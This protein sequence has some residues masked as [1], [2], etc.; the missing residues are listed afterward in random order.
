MAH[1]WRLMAV[2]ARSTVLVVLALAASLFPLFFHLKINHTRLCW[3]EQDRAK[4]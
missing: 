4:T 1:A 2:Q 3:K